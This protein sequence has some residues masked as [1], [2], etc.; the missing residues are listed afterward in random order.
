MP[1]SNR[2][3]TRST[4]RR[5]SG[6]SQGAVEVFSR[7][8]AGLVR[9]VLGFLIR[10]RAEILIVILLVV[11][12]YEIHAR[13][14]TVESY[15]LITAVPAAVLLWPASR[16]FV[17]R[18]FWCVISRH[19]MRACV[20]QI[21]SMMNFSGWLPWMLWARPT[22][23]GERIFLW[24]RPGICIDDLNDRT[25]HVAVSCWARDARVRRSR[26]VAALVIVDVIRREPLTGRKSTIH[27]PLTLVG[28][29][30]PTPP[31]VVVS[32]GAR[33]QPR[34]FNPDKSKSGPETVPPTESTQDDEPPVKRPRKTT[35][36][37]SKPSDG[38]VLRRNDSGEDLS[39]YV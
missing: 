20:V 8:G 14:S 21:R 37:G 34:L 26:R 18:R 9:D 31:P 4:S 13:L 7:P 23:V 3:S 15:I 25:E 6:R 27:S 12:W 38:P 33:K 10:M 17:I 11:A 30:G 36:N 29:D 24:M 39:D 22:P 1:K 28:A 5:R 16:R 19:R 2:A 32:A 35:T